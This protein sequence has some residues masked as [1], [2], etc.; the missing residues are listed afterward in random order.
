MKPLVAI[1]G[2]TNVGKSTLYNRLVGKNKAVIDDLPGLTRD[3][4][5]AEVIWEGKDFVLVDTGGFEPLRPDNIAAQ[6]RE[7]TQLAIEEADSII[8]L[9]DGRAGLNPTD[10][11]IVRMLQPSKKPIFYVINKIDGPKQREDMVEFYQLGVDSL[12]PISAKNKLG[13][14]EL[15]SEV[16]SCLPVAEVKD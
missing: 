8:F 14:S 5:Y 10:S 7:Q 9:A 2:R 11:E 6:I 3:R 16:T 15:M 12:L 4:N 13:I 1:I